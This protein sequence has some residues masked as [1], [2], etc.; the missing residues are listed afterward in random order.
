VLS[1]RLRGENADALL[2]RKHPL[3]IADSCSG[4]CAVP[5]RFSAFYWLSDPS[6]WSTPLPA[7]QYPLRLESGEL[8]ARCRSTD[9]LSIGAARFRLGGVPQPPP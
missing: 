3:I 1:A 6:K 7:A 8:L 5:S 4:S 9:G 2:F